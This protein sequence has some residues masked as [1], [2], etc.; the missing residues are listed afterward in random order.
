MCHIKLNNIENMRKV[1]IH[2]PVSE[3]TQ[4]KMLKS[5]FEQVFWMVQKCETYC[6]SD[7]L[8]FIW[9]FSRSTEGLKGK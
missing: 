6:R 3:T 5:T 4:A 9:H 1:T 8:I 7:W 2:P